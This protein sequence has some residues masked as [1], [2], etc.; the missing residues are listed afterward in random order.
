MPWHSLACEP[1]YLYPWNH[2]TP[3]LTQ[4]RAGSAGAAQWQEPPAHSG[5]WKEADGGFFFFLGGQ[6]WAVGGQSH[7]VIVRTLTT[8]P[9]LLEF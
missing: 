9:L 1:S 8:K 6:K 7:D 2:L 4:D 5:L 3:L